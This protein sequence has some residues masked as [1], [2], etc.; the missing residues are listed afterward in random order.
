M[1]V[2]P[3]WPHCNAGEDDSRPCQDLFGSNATAEGG[4]F[5][6]PD[7]EYTSIEAQKSVDGLHARTRSHIQC[8]H[9]HMPLRVVPQEGAAV[10]GTAQPSVQ[11][12]GLPAARPTGGGEEGRWARRVC[13]HPAR[14]VWPA[15]RTGTH[16]R[17]PVRRI[18]RWGWP[19]PRERPPPPGRLRRWRPTRDRGQCEAVACGGARPARQ[20]CS[21]HTMQ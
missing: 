4:V 12:G 19:R 10:S 8:V 13:W 15:A 7:S 1:R 9:Q 21:L 11:P 14:P 18:G 6:R 5:A 17:F 2:C 20:P 16:R 3:D